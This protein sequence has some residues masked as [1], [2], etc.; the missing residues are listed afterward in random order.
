MLRTPWELDMNINENFMGTTTKKKKSSI[1]TPLVWR[2]L[3]E[4][5]MGMYL[6]IMCIS[7]AC[8][9]GPSVITSSIDFSLQNLV[10]G[11]CLNFQRQK[12][13]KKS[14]SPPTF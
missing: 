6:S 2:R 9:I 11:I 12:T 4:G 10:F 13:L 8:A 1:P 3:R 7:V 5:G 14:I